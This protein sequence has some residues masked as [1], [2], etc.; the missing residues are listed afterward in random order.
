MARLPA[1]EILVA[2]EEDG[3]FL[4]NENCN[5]ADEWTEMDMGRKP[6]IMQRYNILAAAFALFREK[7]YESTSTREIATAAGMERGLLHHYYKQKE[8]ILFEMYT[9]FIGDILDFIR[10]E[11]KLELDSLTCVAVFD[12]LYYKVIASKKYLLVLLNDVLANR[13]LTKIK[14]EKTMDIYEKMVH[15]SNE[16]L[17]ISTAVAIGAEVELLLNMLQGTLRITFNELAEIIIKLEFLMLKIDDQKIG[18]IISQAKQIGESL[19][20]AE[21]EEYFKTQCKWYR[22]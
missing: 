7:G 13:N 2:V 18:E 4:Y 21:F 10:D 17:F 5:Y 12:I 22:R 11:K 3:L 14:I 9:E 20:V 15:V 19:K 6:N 8:D 1:A 16:E